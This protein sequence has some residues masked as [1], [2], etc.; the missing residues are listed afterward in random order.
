[1]D[2]DSNC[3]GRDLVSLDVFDKGPVGSCEQKPKLS[4]SA[5]AAPAIQSQK[6]TPA[7]P[8]CE[9]EETHTA[10]RVRRGLGVSLPSSLLAMELKPL[11]LQRGCRSGPS[12][13]RRRTS[14]L[15]SPCSAQLPQKKKKGKRRGKT[16]SRP[17]GG[18]ALK[19]A[20]GN[21]YAADTHRLQTKLIYK[22]DFYQTGSYSVQENGSRVSTGWQGRN[23]PPGPDRKSAASMAQKQCRGL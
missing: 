15:P 8:P 1:M 16:S 9:E 2:L 11:P 4:P 18:K 12:A 14:S 20:G 3:P 5:E 23:H 7:P 10:P 6:Q 13:S 19:E 22:A 17:R 21:S